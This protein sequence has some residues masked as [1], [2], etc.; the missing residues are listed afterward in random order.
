MAGGQSL[1][2]RQYGRNVLQNRMN[3]YENFVEQKLYDISTKK[4]E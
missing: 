1:D 2:F 4:Y 3:E